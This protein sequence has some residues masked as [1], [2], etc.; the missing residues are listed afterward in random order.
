[1]ATGAE[2][3]TGAGRV[4]GWGGKSSVGEGVDV[5]VPRHR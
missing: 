1:M 5:G 3:V 2:M 4:K